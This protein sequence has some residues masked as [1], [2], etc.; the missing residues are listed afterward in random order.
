VRYPDN[1]REISL[2]LLAKL[3][4]EP[5]SWIGSTKLCG[6]RRLLHFDNATSSCDIQA[7]HSH[8]CMQM[9]PHLLDQIKTLLFLMPV[10]G[11]TVDCEWVGCSTDGAL[12]SGSH[13]L[14]GFDVLRWGGCWLDGVDYADRLELQRQIPMEWVQVYRSPGLCDAFNEQLCNPL[15]EG[16]VIRHKQQRIIMRDNRCVDH[17]LMFK[18]KHKTVNRVLRYAEGR[19]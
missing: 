17:P 7:K 13:R 9:P 8:E 15:S 11:I 19:Q 6:R 4:R 16:L 3:D 18:C 1:P 10:D 5:G 14:V 2:D 12:E